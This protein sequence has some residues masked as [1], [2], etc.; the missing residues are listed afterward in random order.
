MQQER[1]AQAISTFIASAVFSQKMGSERSPEGHM[2]FAIP[3]RL[4]SEGG[5]EGQLEQEADQC[6]SKH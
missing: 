6:P 4:A 5:L 2:E 3:N 1:E